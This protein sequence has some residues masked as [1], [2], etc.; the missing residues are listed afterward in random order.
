[1]SAHI[2]QGGE[3]LMIA[4]TTDLDGSRL[5]GKVHRLQEITVLGIIDGKGAGKYITGTD[6]V[7][8]VDLD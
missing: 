2:G 7:Q 5:V 3:D 6:G 1:M 4:Y 8:C